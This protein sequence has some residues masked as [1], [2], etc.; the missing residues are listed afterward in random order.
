MGYEIVKNS[1]P[2]NKPPTKLIA[3][4]YVEGFHALIPKLDKLAFTYDI[5]P[6]H[7]DMVLQN[8]YSKAGDKDS[9]K[10]LWTSGKHLYTKRFSLTHPETQEK[11]LIEASP[12]LPKQES[13]KPPAFMRFEFNPEKLGPKGMSFLHTQLIEV[14]FDMYPWAAI[15]DGCRVTRLDLAVDL[16]GVATDELIVERVVWG[17]PKA[18][19]RKCIF[20]PEGKLETVD[21]DYRRGKLS[22]VVVYNK[23]KELADNK[24]PSMFGGVP[25]TRVELRLQPNRSL[26]TLHKMKNVFFGVSVICPTKTAPLPCSED[27][28][29]FFL[30]SC[31]L[32]GAAAALSHL[33]TEASKKTFQ[34]ALEGTD[35]KVWRPAK[36]W[37][38]FKKSLAQSG[39]IP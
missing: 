39:L 7:R 27:T 4:G 30:D 31:R 37:P 11:V 3:Y 2:S 38:A 33:P 19:K 18:A 1:A 26:A 34:D 12:K 20:S 32:R 35:K 21:L 22:P 8:L 29:T 14:F 28:W 16:V 25:F 9:L 24:A 5:P 17:K 15:A 10:G 36:L 6:G 13:S 23:A